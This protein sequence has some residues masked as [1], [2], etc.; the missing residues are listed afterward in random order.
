MLPP[1]RCD[2]V[3]EAAAPDAVGE[4]VEAHAVRAADD[5]AGLADLRE[6]AVAQRRVGVALDHQRGHHRRRARAVG[7]HLVE[8]GVD[9]RVRDR[10][11]HVLD[12]LG[13]RRERRVAGHA[14]HRLAAGVDGVQAALVAAL[15][16][17]L[18]RCGGRPCPRARWRR[19]RRSTAAGA[20]DRADEPCGRRARA[21]RNPRPAS[22]ACAADPRMAVRP[23]GS[24]P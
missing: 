5:E 20:G 16:Q 19:V 8:R 10:E 14:E 4:V 22:R 9:A 17:V 1:R 7:D 13:Q 18:D 21:V 15:Q 24:A 3:A 2:R 11:H 23:R 6:H 12:R